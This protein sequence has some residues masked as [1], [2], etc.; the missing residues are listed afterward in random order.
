VNSKST[1]ASPLGSLARAASLG[2]CLALAACGPSQNWSGGSSYVTVGGT[3]AGLVGTVGLQNGSD[4]LTISNNGPFQF[5]L[6]IANGANYAVTIT[7]QPGGASCALSGGSGTASGNVTSV[8]VVCRQ[9]VTVG[10][11]VAGL[12]G[13]VVLQNNGGDTL[14]TASNGAFTFATA[15][16]YGS[17]YA[18][19]VKT[20]PVGQTCTVVNGA[21]AANAAVTNVAVNCLP[22][23]VFKLR[24]LPASYA[25]GKAVAYSGYRAGG[26]GAGEVL[27]AANVDQDLDLLHAAGF[28][29]LRLFGSDPAAQVILARAKLKETAAAPYSM[30]FQLGIYLEG[31]P[32]SCLD[33][34]NSSQIA[35]GIALAN[36]YPNSVVTVSVGNETSFA[37][38]LP[39]G[40]LASYINTVRSQVAQPVT[41]D[42]DYTFYAGLT[43]SGEKPDTILP[44]IDFVSIH[45]YPFLYFNGNP[46]A[47][48]WQQTGV[49]AG[50]ARAAAM[51]NAALASA[52]NSFGRVAGYLYRNAAGATV[53]VGASLPIVIGET[54]WKWR[55]TAPTQA[56]E[57]VTNPAIANPVNAKYY[58]DLLYGNNGAAS[59]EGSVGGPVKIFYFEAFDEAWKG[60]DDGWG[61]WGA[62]RTANYALCGTPA[63][64]ACT[65]P[66]YQG[67]GYFH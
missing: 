60:T 43:A 20:Q 46:G 10:G 22:L 59:W 35:T 9:N 55:T 2:A 36:Q 14:A 16:A 63:G 64:T 5:S 3:V 18:V 33:A 39:V 40:C 21:G 54:G 12:A 24:P 61:L 26:P 58:Y 52:Q 65:S 42:D 31:A 67:A 7:A 4:K 13:T 49:A 57:A 29:L 23:G 45:I 6:L 19:T 28:S 30:K 41:A 1:V 56:I 15:L 8:A 47:W 50:P 53:T 11:T 44:L 51:M 25:T 17:G 62:N 27:S 32:A 34:V 38:N 66:V 37:A 48:D